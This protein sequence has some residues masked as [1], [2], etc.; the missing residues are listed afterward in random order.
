MLLG[1]ED[2]T[3]NSMAWMMHFMIEHPEVQVRMQT[4]AAQVVGKTGMLSQPQ[5][6]ERLSYIEA[7]AHEAMR[8]KPVAP[9]IFLETVEDVVIDGVAIPKRTALISLTMHGGLK[10]T[11]FAAASEFRP[12]RW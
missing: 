10:E 11:H 4:E 7:V 5:D 2:T 8:L 9:I 3:A 12:E 6:A 1:G